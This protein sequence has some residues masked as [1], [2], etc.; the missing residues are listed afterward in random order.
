[1]QVPLCD[2]MW[3]DPKLFPPT[4]SRLECVYEN[5]RTHH[6]FWMG[7]AAGVVFLAKSFDTSVQ[8]LF[9][10]YF[11]LPRRWRGAEN[12]LLSPRD[13]GFK[14]LL[15]KGLLTYSGEV[16][17]NGEPQCLHFG[18]GCKGKFH[19]GKMA[20]QTALGYKQEEMPDAQLA[21]PPTL[22]NPETLCVCTS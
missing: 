20:V 7:D 9:I 19:I 16:M 15:L 1:M 2:S 13:F 11:A 5:H 14:C 18:P 10:D 6:A 21:L 17:I 3:F 4:R 12:V 22:A 8:V